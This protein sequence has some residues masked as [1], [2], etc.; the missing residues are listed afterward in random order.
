MLYLYARNRVSEKAQWKTEVRKLF[1]EEIRGVIQAKY[2]IYAMRA[3]LGVDGPTYLRQHFYELNG[4]VFQP[5]GKDRALYYAYARPANKI[6]ETRGQFDELNK[7]FFIKECPMGCDPQ[8]VLQAEVDWELRLPPVPAQWL[9]MH[10]LERYPTRGVLVGYYKPEQLPWILGNNDK[11]T[12]VYN[13]RLQAEGEE[14]RAGAHTVSF[15]DKQKVMFVIL[16]TD[17]VENT[18]EYRVFHVKDTAKKV[19]EQRM[20]ESGYPLEAK[21]WYYFFRF[22]EEITLGRLNIVDLI[23]NLQTRHQEQVGKYT[24]GEPLFVSSAELLAFREVY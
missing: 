13:V 2:N 19:S 3:R 1:R 17:D 18:K 21:G 4:R 23:K 12:L 9:T 20:R 16:Y 11:G 10:Y 22:D 14:P 5:Y 7:Y 15:Y 8:E 6:D 24:P